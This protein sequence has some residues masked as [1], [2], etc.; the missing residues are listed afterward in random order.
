MRP[1]AAH[2]VGEKMFVQL[3][4]VVL[5]VVIVGVSVALS[6]VLSVWHVIVSPGQVA[7]V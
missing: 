4:V 1:G 6:V 5:S 3:L 2:G 7:A